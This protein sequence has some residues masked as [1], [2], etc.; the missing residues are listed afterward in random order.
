MVNAT[1]S[2]ISKEMEHLGPRVEGHE[3]SE[4]EALHETFKPPDEVG[5]EIAVEDG[6]EPEDDKTGNR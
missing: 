2:P 1:T 6:S 3:K 5:A 4:D